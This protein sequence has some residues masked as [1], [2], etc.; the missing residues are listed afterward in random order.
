[1]FPAPPLPPGRDLNEIERRERDASYESIFGPY[2]NESMTT[3]RAIQ[4]HHTTSHVDIGALFEELEKEQQISESFY[5][6]S[7][8]PVEP[9]LAVEDDEESK[10][11][12]EKIEE[13]TSP[14][15]ARKQSAKTAGK[16]KAGTGVVK[17]SPKNSF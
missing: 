5:A 10:P 13:P 14:V 9:T 1:M 3:A 17:K 2:T 11:V 7:S 15:K 4:T 6:A 16:S 8:T 12:E